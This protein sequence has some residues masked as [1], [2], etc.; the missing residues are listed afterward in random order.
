MVQKLVGGVEKGLG[1]GLLFFLR[2]SSDWNS[3][4]FSFLAAF[5]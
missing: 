5:F 2:F 4:F 3:L 1:A